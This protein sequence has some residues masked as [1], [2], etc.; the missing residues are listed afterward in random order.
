MC[1]ERKNDE[2]DRRG[3]NG[4]KVA[5]NGKSAN[6]VQD[7]NKEVKVANDGQDD[8]NADKN[9]NQYIITYKSCSLTKL[10]F[11]NRLFILEHGHKT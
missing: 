1:F 6:N 11:S 3:E 2:G 8:D 9:S 7:D 10:P 4:D 5:K